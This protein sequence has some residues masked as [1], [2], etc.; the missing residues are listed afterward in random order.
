M[1]SS[2]LPLP[3]LV[4]GITTNLKTGE[5]AIIKSCVKSAKKIDIVYSLNPTGTLTSGV[6]VL[7]L[8]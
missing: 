2:A 8:A 3:L 1:C 7:S 4:S 6:H 5:Y